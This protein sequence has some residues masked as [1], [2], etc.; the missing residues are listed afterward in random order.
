MRNVVVTGCPRAN[1]GEADAL[2]PFGVPVF[3]AAVSAQGTVKATPGA[4]N[5]PPEG[6][7]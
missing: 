5:T 6:T 4:V 7:R 2:G 3:C 1:L